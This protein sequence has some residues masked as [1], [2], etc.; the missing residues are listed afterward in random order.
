VRLSWADTTNRMDA[1]IIARID[2]ATADPKR[3]GRMAYWSRIDP[4]PAGSE[5]VDPP[6]EETALRI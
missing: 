5:L 6:P 2:R 4:R 1:S 3:T